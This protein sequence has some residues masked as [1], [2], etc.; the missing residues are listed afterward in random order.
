MSLSDAEQSSVDGSAWNEFCH[1]LKKAGQVITRDGTPTDPFNR[2][3]GFRYL[4]RILRNALETTLE[5][6]PPAF[7]KLRSVNDSGVKIGAGNPDKMA[8]ARHQTV[9]RPGMPVVSLH[10]HRHRTAIAYLLGLNPGEE[11]AESRWL[12]SN[13]KGLQKLAIGKPHR[14]LMTMTAHIPAHLPFQRR[15]LRHSR[16]LLKDKT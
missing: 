13:L 3:E 16:L 15:C 5:S 10:R 8:R 12:V 6:P 2:A 7:P 1:E 9:Q 4:T 14:Y 11:L